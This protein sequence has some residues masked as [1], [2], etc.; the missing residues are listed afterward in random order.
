LIFIDVNVPPTPGLPLDTKP[1]IKGV[2][3]VFDKM[4]AA[5]SEREATPWSAIVATN[6]SLHLADENVPAPPVEAGMAWSAHTRHP[7]PEHLR[8]AIVQQV[9]EYGKIPDEI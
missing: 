2:N 7:I 1:W 5:E 9:V 8:A 6:F 3:V 4:R